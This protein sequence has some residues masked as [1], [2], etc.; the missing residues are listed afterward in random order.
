M[1][2]KVRTFCDGCGMEEY[3]FRN[4]KRLKKWLYSFYTDVPVRYSAQILDGNGGIIGIENRLLRMLN[5]ISRR[6]NGVSPERKELG[7]K[8]SFTVKVKAP[9]QVVFDGVT[10][11]NFTSLWAKD[12]T[13][14]ICSDETPKTGTTYVSW[15]PWNKDPFVLTV[16]EVENPGKIKMSCGDFQETYVMRE[17]APG[18]T[19]MHF[20]KWY[21]SGKN[22]DFFNQQ[23]RLN[24]L[25]R[26]IELDYSKQKPQGH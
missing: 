24:T 20:T 4:A 13:M 17:V 15:G 3:D 6:F 12:V 23:A 21:E 10:N 16:D 2:Y 5:N 22:E 26:I 19:L 8:K 25:C 7:Y 18:V 9:I 1:H 11:P 14:E